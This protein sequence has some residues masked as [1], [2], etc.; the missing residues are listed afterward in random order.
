MLTAALLRYKVVIFT[1]QGGVG[2]GKQ[3]ADDLKGKVK[4]GF[5][6]RVNYYC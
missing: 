4:E 1:N 3:K 6:V 5:I 2:K